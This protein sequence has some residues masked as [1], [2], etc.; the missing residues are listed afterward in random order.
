MLLEKSQADLRA[1]AEEAA[2]ATDRAP[3]S[4]RQKIG[5][6][7]ESFMDEARADTLGLSPSPTS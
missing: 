1:I 7:Y 6:F 5:D 2:Q 3:G 4:D